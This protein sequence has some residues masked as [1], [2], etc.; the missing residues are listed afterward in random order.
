MR[1]SLGKNKKNKPSRPSVCTRLS[2]GRIKDQGSRIKG[3]G[4]QVPSPVLSLLFVQNASE[5][6]T[7]SLPGGDPDPSLFDGWSRKISPAV[8][9]S[10]AITSPDVGPAAKIDAMSCPS[11]PDRYSKLFN[12]TICFVS[13]TINSAD[14]FPFLC[15]L[16]R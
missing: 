9:P 15:S 3:R 6:A 14:S 1:V 7:C 12:P 4:Q 16:Q 13:C 8:Q 11:D 10:R 5:A 2:T